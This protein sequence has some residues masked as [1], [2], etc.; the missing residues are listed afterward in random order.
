MSAPLLSRPEENVPPGKRAPLRA[1]PVPSTWPIPTPRGGFVDGELLPAGH[2]A[3][4]VDYLLGGG[5]NLPADRA[6]A[7]DWIAVN[8]AA[9][10]SAQ[11]ARAFLVRAV[12]RVVVAGVDQLVDLSTGVAALG[13]P[14]QVVDDNRLR[15]RTIYLHSEPMLLHLARM[16]VPTPHAVVEGS[17]HAPEEAWTAAVTA[18]RFVAGEPVGLLAVGLADLVGSAEELFAVLSGWR[19]AVPPGSWLVLS[20]RFDTAVVRGVEPEEKL[21]ALVVEAGWTLSEPVVR[22]PYWHPTWLLDL[23]AVPP[24]VPVCAATSG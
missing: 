22:A 23:D 14:H 2:A 8:P 24:A 15:A 11:A 20:Q 9:A 6:L 19:A 17:M 13:A 7:Q 10:R 21:A 18:G 1:V 3:R 5:Y 4:A 16:L 12:R